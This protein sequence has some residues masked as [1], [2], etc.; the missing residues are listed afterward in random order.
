MILR[1]LYFDGP[2]HPHRVCHAIL[3]HKAMGKIIDLHI[4]TFD[5]DSQRL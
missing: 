5:M 4:L 1:Q 3:P 2:T